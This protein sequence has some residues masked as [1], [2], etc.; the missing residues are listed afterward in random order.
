MDVSS[1]ALWYRS[2]TNCTLYYYQ[3]IFI[4]MLGSSLFPTRIRLD[5]RYLSRG[6]D[7]MG[8]QIHD[9]HHDVMAS[10]ARLVS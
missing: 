1:F 3:V 7:D 4:Q 8:R 10:P 6:S 2:I 5:H 9:L